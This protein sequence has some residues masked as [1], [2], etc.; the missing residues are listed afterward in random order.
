M[1][2]KILLTAV[3]AASTILSAQAWEKKQAPLMTE[4]GNRVTPENA[5]REYPRPQMVRQEWKNLN[6]LWNYAVVSK[7]DARPQNI[8]QGQI[9]VPFA[10]E[11]ALSGVQKKFTPED[12]LWYETE[13]IV[14]K[15]WKGKRII[16]HFGAVDYASEIWVNDKPVGSHRGSSDAFRIDVTDA[17]KGS[18]P[19]KLTVAV[20][21]PTDTGCQPL[22]KQKL[23]PSGIYYTPVSGIWKTVWME[24]VPVSHIYSMRGYADIDRSEYRFTPILDKDIK[25]QKVRVSV[26]DEGNRIA[27]AEGEP[28]KEIVIKIKNQKLWSPESPFL[29]DM[30]VELMQGS[31]VIDAVDTYFGMRKISTGRDE[32]GHMRLLLNNKP[33]FQTGLLDQGWWP[34]GLLT[35]PSDSAYIFDIEYAK[36]AGFNTLRKHIKQESDRFYYHCDRLGMIVWQDAVASKDTR[37]WSKTRVEPVLSEAESQTFIREFKNLMDQLFNFPSIVQWVVFNE[38]WGQHDTPNMLG[39]VDFYD[40]SRLH[41]VSGWMDYGGG[42]ICDIHR[43]PGPGKIDNAGGYRPLVLG[44]YGGVGYVV[45]DSV[46]PAETKRMHYRNA[47][48]INQYTSDYERIAYQ[49]RILKEQGLSAAI[50]TQISDVEGEINGVMTYDRRHSKLPVDKMKHLNDLILTSEVALKEVM[51][52]SEK[53]AQIWKYTIRW[54]W[55][56]EGWEKDGYD[57]RQWQEGPG[58]FGYVRSGSVHNTPFTEKCSFAHTP[59]TDWHTSQIWLRREIELDQV[60]QNPM[61]YIWYFT[62]AEVYINGT[63]VLKVKGRNAPYPLCEYYRFTEEAK[64]ALKKGRNLIA[65]HCKNT[66]GKHVQAIDLGIYDV[67]SEIK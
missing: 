16:L 33:Y 5:H 25:G 52:N 44:E 64:K 1:I 30:K 22:G 21:D 54:E 28:N 65:V 66:G 15:N 17:L 56:G 9:L 20:T 29:Y 60:P 3:C 40:P 42:D 37:W 18:G 59:K 34:D 13:F 10:I 48:D 57:I 45:K 61:F 12:R 63:L 62:E 41:S 4:W 11:S 55:I 47:S 27:V 49:L 67:V 7:D 46:W 2:R 43:Y 36:N 8:D 19:Q 53:Q 31:K 6:G 23:Q 38:G 39:W 50:Y 51:P 24:P 58:F 14:P 35:P 32:N 26:Y